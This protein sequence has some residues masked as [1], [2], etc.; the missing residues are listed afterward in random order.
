MN[1]KVAPVS[2]SALTL[3]VWPTELFVSLEL[4]VDYCPS[5]ISC[6][7]AATLPSRQS[8]V[9]ESESNRHLC[10]NQDLNLYGPHAA[11]FT[12]ET[13]IKVEE[14]LQRTVDLNLNTYMILLPTLLVKYQ[15]VD[16]SLLLLATI[17]IEAHQTFALPRNPGCSAYHQTVVKLSRHR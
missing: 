7:S 5:N 15:S 16:P 9:N 13:F 14:P 3:T 12:I 4:S 8:S 6:G 1:W 17:V 11:T 10:L 2:D